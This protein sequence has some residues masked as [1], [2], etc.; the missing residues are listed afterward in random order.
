MRVGSART[1]RMDEPGRLHRMLDD[2]PSTMLAPLAAFYTGA[3]HGLPTVER[4]AADEVPPEL[5]ALLR[6]PEPLTPRLEDH[7]GENLALRVLERHR[8]GDRY[9]RRVV[10]VRGDGVPVML[11]AIEMNLARLAPALR[12]E[13]LAESVPFGRLLGGAIA[14]PDALLRVRCDAAIAAALEL[15]RTGGWLYGRRRTVADADGAAIATVVE[16]LAPE[17]PPRVRSR[18]TGS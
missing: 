12:A 9:A 3:G 15:P 8:S 6:S 14:D 1:T 18:G 2:D 13:V 16:I 11:G 7:H 10:L 17:P 5:R 4:V